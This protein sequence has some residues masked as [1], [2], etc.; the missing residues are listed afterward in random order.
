M[1]VDLTVATLALQTKTKT[2]T[3][4]VALGKSC[5]GVV[6]LPPNVK[7]PNFVGWVIVFWVEVLLG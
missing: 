2:K 7:S 4:V 6:T 5:H 3:F 1:L